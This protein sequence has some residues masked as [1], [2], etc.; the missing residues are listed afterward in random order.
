MNQLR[1]LS[2]F[3]LISL[4]LFSAC[5]NDDSPALDDPIIM[6]DDTV[7]P[8]PPTASYVNGS[9]SGTVIDKAG[10]AL[11]DVNIVSNN[12]T[13]TTDQNGV[14]AFKDIQLNSFGAL[15]TAEKDGY[16]YNAKVIRPEKDK[17]AFTK[18]MLLEKTL[19]GTV[20]TNSG[21]KVMTNGD[22][23]VDLPAN[24]IKNADGTTYTG[25]VNVYATWLDPT[26]EDLF[27]EM[28][29]D[30]RATDINNSQVQLRTFGM[31]GVELEGD[32]G[33]PLNLA[34]GQT[35]TIELPVPNELLADAPATIP[36][37]HFDEATGYWVEE[38]EATLQGNKYIGTVKHFS[39][40]NCDIPGDFIDLSGTV[41]SE[42]GGVGGL[43]VEVSVGTNGA[44]GY[45]YTNEDGFFN[46]YVPG[47]QALSIKVYDD[48]GVEIYSAEIGP[49]TMDTELDNIVVNPAY[50]FVTFSGTLNCNGA[51][52]SNGYV[53]IDFGANQSIIPVDSDGNFSANLSV[54]SAT[55]VSVTG[56]DL[57]ELQQST[58]L[59]YTIDGLTELELG[60]LN[61]CEIAFDEYFITTVNG[62]T[63]TATELETFAD[64]I[65]ISEMFMLASSPTAEIF[66]HADYLG[67][68]IPSEIIVF[69]GSFINNTQ[70][71]HVSDSGVG[72]LI[73]T[74]TAYDP[75]PGGVIQGTLNG[76]VLNVD[77]GNM[78][79]MT[80]EFKFIVD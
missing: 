46:G 7:L 71:I 50:E 72:A 25:N 19:S 38:G 54:C 22:A 58:A 48:C 1:K 23:S 51:G 2:Y 27:L 78:V 39:F 31:I 60:S 79:P 61:V 67:L 76:Q 49:F 55:E 8:P 70:D 29:G 74:F 21:G 52:V 33:E 32:G 68:N 65:G 13:T 62:S 57:N 45:G 47:N 3:F 53:K 34:D 30:L 18:I 12:N 43:L 24:G 41:I 10:N 42:A 17:M 11:A 40:W 80:A 59:S 37:W 35:A 75:N 20:N 73:L 77:T 5:K 14:F 64:T 6:E 36:L 63:F 44:S 9:I 4:F 28:P 69:D 26:S 56:Y 16:Y 66:F 15:V